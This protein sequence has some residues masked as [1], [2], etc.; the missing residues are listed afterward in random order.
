[1]VLHAITGKMITIDQGTIKRIFKNG[2]GKTV[3]ERK[4]CGSL[5]VKESV[6]LVKEAIAH[7]R[8]LLNFILNL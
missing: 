8:K 1:M 7:E 6:C 5:T 4:S 2:W 3:V